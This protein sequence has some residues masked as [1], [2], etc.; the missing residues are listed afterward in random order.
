M[1]NFDD[2]SGNIPYVQIAASSS[3]WGFNAG[4]PYYSYRP[5]YPL[6]TKWQVGDIIYFNKGSHSFKFGVDILHNYDFQNNL[7]KGNGDLQLPYIG[8][9]HVNDLMNFKN[10]V[11]PANAGTDCD[12]TSALSAGQYGVG[13]MAVHAA[14]AVALS[15][16]SQLL[17]GI[18]SAILCDQYPG[19]GFFAQDNWKITP[20]LTLELGVRWDH[21]TMPS[22]DPAL[23]APHAAALFLARSPIIPP[24]ISISARASASRLT[25]FGSGKTVLRG[26]YGLYYGRI[27]NGN[28]ARSCSIPAALRRNTRY[29]QEQPNRSR[30]SQDLQPCRASLL[31]VLNLPSHPLLLLAEP[32]ASRSEASTT[33]FCSRVWVEARFSPLSYLGGWVAGCRTS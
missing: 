19:L 32:E 13:T 33:C 24:I 10:G 15:L 9:L 6:E 17:P 11:S 3:G 22:P 14:T 28:I 16:L 25:V 5:A 29:V 26:G 23:I 2:K 21:E 1:A 20:R 7:Y 8:P 27:T 4:S 31:R 12:T 18:R 30:L